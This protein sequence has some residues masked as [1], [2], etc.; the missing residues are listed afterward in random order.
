MKR[1]YL[2]YA[3]IV[4]VAI[5]FCFYFFKSSKT[6][7]TSNVNTTTT[8]IGLEGAHLMKIFDD[9]GIRFSYPDRFSLNIKMPNCVIYDTPNREKL[10]FRISK[11]SEIEYMRLRYSGEGFDDLIGRVLFVYK[12][13]FVKNNREGYGFILK[14]E[15]NE[16]EK[17]TMWMEEIEFKHSPYYVNF[18][19]EYVTADREEFEKLADRI[20]A[21]FHIENFEGFKE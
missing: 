1:K 5:C 9:D 12:G 8:A 16:K 2:W 18:R 21:S 3:V 19:F 11:K 14:R 10:L 20:L 6:K 7:A 17:K 4:S 13:D 15:F